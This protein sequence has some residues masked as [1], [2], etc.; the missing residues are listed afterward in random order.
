M[1]EAQLILYVLLGLGLSQAVGWWVII[2][3]V[4]VMCI[5]AAVKEGCR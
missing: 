4:T 3:F 2:G 5:G 1:L